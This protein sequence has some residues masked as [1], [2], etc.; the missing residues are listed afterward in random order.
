LNRS[1]RNPLRIV[2]HWQ[3][4]LDEWVKNILPVYDHKWLGFHSY[5][6]EQITDT[7]PCP[8]LVEWAE[9][10]GLPTVAALWPA[11]VNWLPFNSPRFTWEITREIKK[12]TNFNGFSI[13]ATII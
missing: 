5:S 3:I 11:N 10:V 13:L 2:H 8:D 9:A 1:G 6:A 12:A 7:R 4:P